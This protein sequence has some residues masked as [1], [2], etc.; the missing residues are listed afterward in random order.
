MRGRDKS[1]EPRGVVK[2]P[3]D[4]KKSIPGKGAVSEAA[5]K[6]SES[7]RSGARSS[8]RRLLEETG[9][10]P[11]MYEETRVVL[12]PIDPHLVNVRWDLNPRETEIVR[13]RSLSG[14]RSSLP[15]L[16]FFETAPGLGDARESRDHFDIEID[17]RAGNWY[18][19]LWQGGKTYF[20]EIGFRSASGAFHPLAR[21]NT[22][23]IPPEAPSERAAE[24][25]LVVIG[26]EKTI[27]T[28]ELPPPERKAMSVIPGPKPSEKA[29]EE[30]PLSTEGP[31][32]PP[33][34]KK[35]LPVV[36]KWQRPLIVWW[37]LPEGQ[38]PPL[39]PETLRVPEGEE[40]SDLS[41]QA[42][43]AFEAGVSS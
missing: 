8:A 25:R 16:R 34:E 11:S 41:T 10:L 38:I 13:R 27:E 7:R 1:R 21:S 23:E 30:L 2:R 24:S 36:V 31:G 20:V 42:E 37:G 33:S 26:G 9:S 15:V 39:L 40:V 12:T 32:P 14:K 17:L 29:I 18:V 43:E 3:L 28:F 5:R 4:P 19:P 22:A 35:S 6:S